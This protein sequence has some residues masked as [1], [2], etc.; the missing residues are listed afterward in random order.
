M[1]KYLDKNALDDFLDDFAELTV[2]LS[3]LVEIVKTTGG[4]TPVRA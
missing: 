4:C 2:S 1:S 3:F